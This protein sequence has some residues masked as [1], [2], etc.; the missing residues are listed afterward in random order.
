MP[1]LDTGD[2]T[3]FYTDDG[4]GPPVL[5]VHG[6]TGDSHDWSWQI[7]ALLDGGYR[8]IAADLRGHGRSSVPA[9]GY[10]PKQFAAD[11]VTLLDHLGTGPVIVMGHSLGTI[12]GSTLA[13]EHPAHVA[14]LVVVDPTYGFPLELAD[15]LE[16]TCNALRDDPYAGALD[17]LRT[18]NHADTTPAHLKT[19]HRRR[20]LG[21]QP[22]VIRDIVLNLYEEGEGWLMQP[23]AARYL[24]GR[25]CPVL[26]I[27]RTDR[28]L[29]WDRALP[30][31]PPSEVVALESSHFPHQ[32]RAEEC[33]AIVLGWLEQVAAPTARLRAAI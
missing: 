32:E 29:D 8:V 22:H 33:N 5:L 21:T 26:T 12:I 25:R 4:D 24:A 31:P 6:W 17:N 14:A 10:R 1:F 18:F 11:L 2:V 16:A 23:E 27:R 30:D 28:N 20:M 19:W 3:L 7:P 13:V 15:Y 9:D